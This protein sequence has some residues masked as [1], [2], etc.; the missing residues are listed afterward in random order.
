MAESAETAAIA[1]SEA[2]REA[3]GEANRATEQAAESAA[4]HRAFTEALTLARQRE[5][6]LR[7]QVTALAA[8]QAKRDAALIPQARLDQA[9]RAAEMAEAKREALGVA[10]ELCMSTSATFVLGMTATGTAWP[11][12][13]IMAVTGCASLVGAWAMPRQG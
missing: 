10:L 8:E 2:V 7:D 1:A 9:R 11:M 5:K 6:R 4:R 3:D 12:V 13:I